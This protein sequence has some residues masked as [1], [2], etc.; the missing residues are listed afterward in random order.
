MGS[1]SANAGL[2][3]ALNNT[4]YAVR[5]HERGGR[6][7]STGLQPVRPAAILA[8][9]SALQAEPAGRIPAGRTG[10]KPVLRPATFAAKFTLFDR[11]N[12]I[13]VPAGNWI[14]SPWTCFQSRPTN[15]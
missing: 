8:A 11:V 4:I 3:S 10:W 5:L 2:P 1:P 14:P 9:D 15:A 12:R 7:R 6:G 13:S